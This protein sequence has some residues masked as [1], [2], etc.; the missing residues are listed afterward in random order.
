MPLIAAS[1]GKVITFL[2]LVHGKELEQCQYRAF[3]Q[4]DVT[5]A[6]FDLTIPLPHVSRNVGFRPGSYPRMTKQEVMALYDDAV[7]DCPD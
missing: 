2:Q 1:L 4:E 6:M 3:R 5:E 7:A